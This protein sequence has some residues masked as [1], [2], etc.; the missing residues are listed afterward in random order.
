ML[1]ELRSYIGT[2][3]C[4]A[5]CLW[6]ASPAQASP[7]LPAPVLSVTAN[8]QGGIASTNSF[9]SICC[10]EDDVNGDGGKGELA[11]AS[12]EGS[13]TDPILQT[14]TQ[15]CCDQ[16]DVQLTY[17]FEIVGPTTRLVPIIV[18]ANGQ[19]SIDCFPD[20]CASTIA[21]EESILSTQAFIG[22]V[23]SYTGN[24]GARFAIGACAGNSTLSTVGSPFT[25]FC[26]GNTQ[27]GIGDTTFADIDT[28]VLAAAG[29]VDSIAMNASSDGREGTDVSAGIDPII[30][31]DPSFAEADE[32]SIIYSTAPGFENAPAVTVPEPSTWTMML[33]GFGGLGALVMRS[34]R[35]RALA[36][37]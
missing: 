12:F 15:G 37:A 24:N 13:P 18:L 27:T 34:R 35:T 2:A 22:I 33:F 19:T 25:G 26:P 30:E 4:S 6:L 9:V 1:S 20:S 7:I 8:T 23:M 36:T 14:S 29:Q 16:S 3:I 28:S 10:S 5:T 21:G 17:S 31:I 32:Y 11:T